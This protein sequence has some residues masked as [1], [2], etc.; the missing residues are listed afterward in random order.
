MNNANIGDYSADKDARFGCKG[1]DKFW[2]GYKRHVA[3]DMKHGIIN[4]VA[5]TP[6]NVADDKGLE[7]GCPD[8]GMVVATAV[9]F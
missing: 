1:K 9:Q 4:N 3:V 7:L 6:A 5:V 8:G 2:F